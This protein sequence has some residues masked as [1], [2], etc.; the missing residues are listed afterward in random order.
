[1]SLGISREVPSGWQ[2]IM[3]AGNGS[4]RTGACWRARYRPLVNP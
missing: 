1:M 4:A 3:V 2:P